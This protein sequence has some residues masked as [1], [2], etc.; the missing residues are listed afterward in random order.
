M[1]VCENVGLA[2]SA[3]SGLLSEGRQEEKFRG[4]PHPGQETSRASSE[5]HEGVCVT[6]QSGFKSVF[7]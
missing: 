2:P 7:K 4:K 5:Q 6:S 1:M 3:G